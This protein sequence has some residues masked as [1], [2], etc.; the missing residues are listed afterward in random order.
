MGS[1]QDDGQ[2]FLRA[3]IGDVGFK[4]AGTGLAV[5]DGVGL[6]AGGLS[7]VEAGPRP[8]SLKLKTRPVDKAALVPCTPLPKV[9]ACHRRWAAEGCLRAGHQGTPA[10]QL[11]GT[12]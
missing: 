12:L 3:R 9:L 7:E 6:G 10:D 5:R 4:E 8:D 11:L 1:R 2:E